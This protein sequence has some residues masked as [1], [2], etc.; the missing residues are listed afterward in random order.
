[1][2][3]SSISTLDFLMLNCTFDLFYSPTTNLDCKKNIER[4]DSLTDERYALQIQTY[5]E[6]RGCGGLPSPQQY[7]FNPFV[8]KTCPCTYQ[9]RARFN[10][11][12]TLFDKYERFGVLPFTGSHSDQ[13]A[14]TL[15]AFDVIRSL[16]HSYDAK[17]AK[18]DKANVR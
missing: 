11:L 12:W 18:R 8:L 17:A 1:M 9:N 5:R 14:P 6:T 4:F 7:K 16:K 2:R 13:P 10:H 3:E 15:E